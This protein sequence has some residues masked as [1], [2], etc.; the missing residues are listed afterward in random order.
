MFYLSDQS[1]CTVTYHYWWCF[2]W[3]ISQPHTITSNVLPEWSVCVHSH[4]PLLVMFYLSDQS[5]CTATYHYWWC[6]TWVISQRA[7]RHTTT[8]D[9]LPEWSVSVHSHIPLLVMFYLSDQSAVCVPPAPLSLPRW[10][11]WGPCCGLQQPW[12]LDKKKPVHTQTQRKQEVSLKYRLCIKINQVNYWA[13]PWTVTIL[14][15]STFLISQQNQYSVIL[16]TRY[17]Y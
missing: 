14:Y 16:F 1:A 6:F 17:Y 10:T 2:T 13:T 3:V 4:I 15:F 5:A 7:Q 12:T 11:G 8:G 9:V